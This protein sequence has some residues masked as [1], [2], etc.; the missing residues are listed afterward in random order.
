M[1]QIP[2]W[3]PYACGIPKKRSDDTANCYELTEVHHVVHVPEAQR[4]LEDGRIGAKLIYDESRL[5]KYRI[6]VA[7]LSANTWGNGSIYGNVQFTFDWHEIIKYLGLKDC[8]VYWVEALQYRPPAYRF[9]LADSNL[10]ISDVLQYDPLE[11]YGPLRR[12]GDIWYWN[13]KYTSEF[14][15]KADLPLGLCKGIE[16]VS[17][18]AMCRPYGE[19]CPDGDASIS[20]ISGRMMAFILGRNIRKVNSIMQANGAGQMDY[21]VANIMQ[22]LGKSKCFE[23]EIE[24]PLSRQAVLTGALALYGYGRYEKAK[25]LVSLLANQQVF[26]DALREIV[27]EHFCRPDYQLPHE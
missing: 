9:L 11:A 8:T 25:N 21:G 3:E 13:G 7:W 10:G 24:N 20:E 16:S 18:N 6:C 5:K 4:I 2:E 27:A 22:S 15:I 12:K 23:G 14:M 26:D 1:N 17:H 19:K